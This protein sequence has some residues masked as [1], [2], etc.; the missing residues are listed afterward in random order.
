VPTSLLSD[1][2]PASQLSQPAW[3]PRYTLGADPTE[4]TA[5]NSCSIVMGGCLAIPH[6]LLTRLPAVTKQ[7]MFLLAIV[8]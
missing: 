4:N 7:R 1:E 3:G 5:S 2:Y 6:I 8:A